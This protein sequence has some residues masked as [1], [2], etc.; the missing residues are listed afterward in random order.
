MKVTNISIIFLSLHFRPSHTHHLYLH[1]HFL[2][3]LFAL[4]LEYTIFYAGCPP[5]VSFKGA[6]THASSTDTIQKYSHYWEADP[7]CNINDFIY[8]NSRNCCDDAVEAHSYCYNLYRKELSDVDIEDLELERHAE[9]HHEDQNHLKQNSWIY[10]IN[11]ADFLSLDED[12]CQ[13]DDC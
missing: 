13:T 10:A 5:N 4:A 8:E 9:S 12:Q 6:I 3:L 1:K 11:R 7:A 2:Y